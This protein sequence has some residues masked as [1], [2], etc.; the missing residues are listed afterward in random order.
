MH[1]LAE[2][3]PPFKTEKKT[4]NEKT[5]DK[6]IKSIIENKNILLEKEEIEYKE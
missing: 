4:M 6:L 3:E 5:E 1:V 2:N